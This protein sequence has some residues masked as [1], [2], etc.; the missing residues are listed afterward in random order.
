MGRRHIPSWKGSQWDELLRLSAAERAAMAARLRGL[1]GGLQRFMA[2]GN[3]WGPWDIMGCQTRSTH[4]W[5][6]PA[7]PSKKWDGSIPEVLDC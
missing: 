7:S 3:S 1:S 5:N 6:S 2:A 4:V